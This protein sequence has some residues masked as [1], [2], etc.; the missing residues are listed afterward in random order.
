MPFFGYRWQGLLNRHGNFRDDR[1]EVE[2]AAA[3]SP[4]VDA[5]RRALVRFLNALV[6]LVCGPGVVDVIER[7]ANPHGVRFGAVRR[8]RG[9]D[10]RHVLGVGVRTAG[11]RRGQRLDPCAPLDL[12]R[13]RAVAAHATRRESEVKDLAAALRRATARGRMR[14]E[15][16]RARVI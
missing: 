16:K 10:L 3:A 1:L 6:D 11:A 2:R 9:L 8:S 7:Y 14:G 13:P 5:R 15:T 12:C 4:V